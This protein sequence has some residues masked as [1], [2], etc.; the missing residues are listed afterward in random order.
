MKWKCWREKKKVE[1]DNI[2]C[3]YRDIFS[4]KSGKCNAYNH[5]IEIFKSKP[6]VI[7]EKIGETKYLFMMI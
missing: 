3:E 5:K 7:R 1:L 6:Y 4:E 2:L